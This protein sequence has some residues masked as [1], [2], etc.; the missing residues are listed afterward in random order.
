L[1]EKKIGTVAVVA[2]SGKTLQGGLGALREELASAGITDPL[3]FEVPKSKMAPKRVQAALEGGVEL[4]FVWGGDGMV[5]RCVGS[6]RFRMP[7]S[8]SSPPV[9]EPLRVEHQDARTF[10]PPVGSAC[11][12]PPQVR[13]RPHQRQHFTV[14]A[15]AG[16]GALM[17]RDADGQLKDRLGAWRTSLPADA[18]L[19]RRRAYASTATSGSTA[20]AA[21]SSATSGR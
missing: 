4:I 15:G 6:R 19:P 9:R 17:I 16:L 7:R 18:G 14:M 21:Y 1:V 5:Q 8:P 12:V 20:V 11:T 3:W 2:H 10:R 13:R